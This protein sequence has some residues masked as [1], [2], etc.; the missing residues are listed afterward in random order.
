MAV[1]SGREEDWV[2]YKQLRRSTGFLHRKERADGWHKLVCG[3]A[4]QQTQHGMS[5]SLVGQLKLTVLQ[6]KRQ[7]RAAQHLAQHETPRAGWC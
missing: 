1:H 3:R 4:D 2:R 6:G 7:D 5:A